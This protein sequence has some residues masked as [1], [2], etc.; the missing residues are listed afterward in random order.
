MDRTDDRRDKHPLPV[1]AEVGGEGGSYADRTLQGETLAGVSGLPRVGR[2]AGPSPTAAPP[3]RAAEAADGP[4]HDA[5]PAA[6]STVRYAT[7]PPVP[8]G[9]ARGHRVESPT[10]RAGLI[11]AAAGAGAA[12]VAGLLWKRR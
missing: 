2:D 1:T 8:P 5:D 12:V 6:G 11:G 3:M 10:W 7:E 4:R 9:A